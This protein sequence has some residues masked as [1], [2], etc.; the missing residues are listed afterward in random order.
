MVPE[1]PVKTAGPVWSTPVPGAKSAPGAGPGLWVLTSN[2]TSRATGPAFPLRDQQPES[3]EPLL[4][5][6]I[7]KTSSQAI[8][9]PT[10]TEL[11]H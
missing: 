7:P 11:L 9:F 3:V 10:D 5:T 2:E 8:T 6:P 4:S 1:L